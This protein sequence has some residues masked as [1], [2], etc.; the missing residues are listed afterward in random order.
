MYLEEQLE[1]MPQTLIKCKKVFIFIL[2]LLVPRI[3]KG[4]MWMVEFEN[5]SIWKN[6]YIGWTYMSDSISKRNLYF[7]SLEKALHFCK[8]YGRF[9]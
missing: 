5:M 7:G 4:Y 8:S 1:Y 2:R 3:S 9:L 6:N